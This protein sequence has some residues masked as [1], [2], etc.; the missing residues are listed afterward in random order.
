MD[1]FGPWAEGLKSAPARE[2]RRGGALGPARGAE[3]PATLAG[4]RG[5]CVRPS[6]TAYAVNE[7]PQPQPPVAFGLLKVKPEPMTFV[8]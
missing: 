1:Y 4:I 5:D 8:T 6:R 3:R 7:E 2:R